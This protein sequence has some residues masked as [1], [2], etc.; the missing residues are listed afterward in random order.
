[1]RRYL[2]V[3]PLILKCLFTY[4]FRKKKVQSIMKVIANR[5]KRIYISNDWQN[6]NM[7]L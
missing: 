5:K 3:L 7:F 4:G 2:N 1:M 6:S